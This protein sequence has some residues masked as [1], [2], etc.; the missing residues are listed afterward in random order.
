MGKK[1]T[2]AQL[3]TI[4]LVAREIRDAHGSRVKKVTVY[5]MKWTDAIKHASKYVLN[6]DEQASKRKTK[7]KTKTRK[8]K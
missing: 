7:A 3:K 8:R 6:K 1:L 4:T 5:N 2:R